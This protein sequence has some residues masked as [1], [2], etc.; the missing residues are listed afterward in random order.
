LKQ[1]K[2]SVILPNNKLAQLTYHKTEAGEWVS[3]LNNQS[4]ID[5][6]ALLNGEELKQEYV[7]PN[8]GD[9]PTWVT[10]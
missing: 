10:L 7:E 9:I 5:L 8:I 6:T 1:R 2:I 3:I 4:M